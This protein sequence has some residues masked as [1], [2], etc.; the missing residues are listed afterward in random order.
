VIIVHGSA[1]PH[2][3]AQACRYAAEGIEC[4]LVGAISARVS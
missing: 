3:I 1:R 4:D 2:G